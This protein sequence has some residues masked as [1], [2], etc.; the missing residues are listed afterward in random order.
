MI[1]TLLI[2]ALCASLIANVSQWANRA[3]MDT[4]NAKYR[5]RIRTLEATIEATMRTSV[6]EAAIEAAIPDKGY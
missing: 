5:T 4:W 2:A 6:R 1:T 3:D